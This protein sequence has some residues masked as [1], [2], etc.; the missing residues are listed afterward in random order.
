[1][2]DRLD[3][4][5]DTVQVARSTTANANTLG[6]SSKT[7]PG[8]GVPGVDRSNHNY[9]AKRNPVLLMR[10]RNAN[11]LSQ[12]NTQGQG[13]QQHN[14]GGVAREVSEDT[15]HGECREG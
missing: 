3:W 15:K 11:R 10:D 7:E 13:E 14:Q 2:R 4:A 5:E 12:A 8:T 1:M 9:L 6:F